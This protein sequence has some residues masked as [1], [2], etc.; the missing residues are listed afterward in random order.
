MGSKGSELDDLTMVADLSHW[1]NVAETDCNDMDLTREFFTEAVRWAKENNYEV[2]HESHRK[3]FLHSPWLTRD[4][5]MGSKGSELDDL[6]MVADLSHWI[7]V[8]ETDCNDMDLTA[9]IEAM[10]PRFRHI[11]MRV[12]YDHG[13]QVPDP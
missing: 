8:A 7:N 5:L 10:A 4:F 11:H 1:I 9:V 12:G 3:R 2:H 13:P 6:T